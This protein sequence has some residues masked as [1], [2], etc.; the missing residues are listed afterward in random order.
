MVVMHLK[1]VVI[2]SDLILGLDPRPAGDTPADA[3]LDDLDAPPSAPLGPPPTTDGPGSG[4]QFGPF[5]SN[6]HL[7]PRPSVGPPR[8]PRAAI[9]TPTIEFISPPIAPPVAEDVPIPNRNNISMTNLTT[10]NFVRKALVEAGEPTP[11]VVPITPGVPSNVPVYPMYIGDTVGPLSSDQFTE[12]K[13]GAAEAPI[14]P[15]PG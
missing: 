13:K 9:P 3:E 8:P 10:G 2:S 12:K 14:E 5:S 1:L 11:D 7:V 4:P 15:A 6:G